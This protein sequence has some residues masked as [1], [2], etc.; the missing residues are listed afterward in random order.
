[1]EPFLEFRREDRPIERRLFEFL[2][3]L[4]VRLLNHRYPQQYL[5]AE[6][7]SVKMKHPQLQPLVN[8]LLAS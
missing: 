1:V 8:S 3:F 4:F 7:V 5:E 2:R 6:V